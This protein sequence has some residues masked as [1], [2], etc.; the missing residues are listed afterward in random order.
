MATMKATL[1]ATVLA[2]GAITSVPALAWHHSGRHAGG[3]HGSGNYH[4]H[5]VPRARLGIFAA[6]PIWYYLPPLSYAPVAVAPSGPQIYIERG[7]LQSGAE[8]PAGYWYYCAE[9]EA[10]YPYVKECPG[11]WQPVAPLAPPSQ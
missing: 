5:S 10:Y 6:V 4:S 1:G 9:A 2:L 7:D 11:A 8:L 3:T